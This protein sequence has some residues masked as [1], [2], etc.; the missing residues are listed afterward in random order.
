MKLREVEKMVVVTPFK[1]ITF[2]KEKINKLDDVM[3]PPYD[4]ISEEMQKKLPI[5]SL[6]ARHLLGA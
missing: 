5:F 3:S 1:G 2:N 4:V 6:L